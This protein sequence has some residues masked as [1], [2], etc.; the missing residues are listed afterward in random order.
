MSKLPKVIYIMGSPGAGK[1]TQAEMLA[2]KIGYKQFSTGNAFR[3]VAAKNSDLGRRVKETIDNGYLAS[4]EMAAE[5]VMTAVKKHLEKGEGLVFDGTPRTVPEAKIV[6]EFFVTNNYGEPLPIYLKVDKEEMERRNSKRVFCLNAKGGD[7]PVFTKDD[8][9]KCE[10]EGGHEGRRP[11]DDPEK[12]VT[13]WDEFQKQTYPVIEGYRQ[14][15][16]LREVDGM[17]SI[18]EVHEEVIRVV[19]SF[20]R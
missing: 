20:E 3:E 8:K 17:L 6:D 2:K 4:P 14:G 1:G 16:I 5:I 15:D 13:R 19:Y 9:A 12:F 18:G 11:D 10:E 7:F